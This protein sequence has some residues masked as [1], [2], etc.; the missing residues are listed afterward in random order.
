MRKQAARKYSVN[1]SSDIA[2]IA[3]V[4]VSHESASTLEECLLRLRAAHGVA[5]IRV[6]DNASQ[7]GTL[8]LTE[9][10]R[11]SLERMVNEIMDAQ[12]DELC[13]EGNRRN[14]YRERGLMTRVG[15]ITLRI[16]KLREGT[17]FPDELVRPY[18][19]VDRSVVAAVREVYARGLS[20]R[21]IEKAADALE[22]GSLSPSRVSAMTANIASTMRSKRLCLSGSAQMPASLT[23][24]GL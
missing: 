2:D 23:S 3:V 7:D 20:T 19:R 9:A 5:E 10:A 12:A 18:S 21:K 1:S 15:E 11:L 16:P 6:I 13:G 24:C 14:G 22:F 4:V 17:Y 8:D